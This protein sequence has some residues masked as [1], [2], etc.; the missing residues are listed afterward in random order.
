[1]RTAALTRRVALGAF[2]AL[3]L[4]AC[5]PTE[6][7]PAGPPQVLSPDAASKAAHAA[8]DAAEAE[9]QRVTVSIVDR[10]G[11]ERIRLTSDGAGPQS[12]ESA[13][14]K[15]FT[16]AAWG[17]PTSELD[18]AALRG[19]PGTLFL[20]GGVPVIAGSPIAGIGVAGAPSGD[21][22]EE[23]ARAGLEAVE[24]ELP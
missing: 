22:D 3:A 13:K 16:A 24:A 1:M 21:L 17:Q 10:S 15:A 5:T 4:A 19:I 2:A 12:G 23:F 14:R 9:G 8:L 7:Q 20:G 11:N 18:G 6:P